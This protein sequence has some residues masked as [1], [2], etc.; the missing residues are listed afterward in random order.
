MSST[1]HPNQPGGTAPRDPAELSTAD[2]LRQLSDQVRTLVT[3]EVQLAKAEVTAKGKA[4]GIGAGLAGAGTML[5]LAGGLAF[6]AA[7]IA[8]LALVL[9]VWASALIVGAVLVAMGGLLALVAKKEISH[10]SP[11]VPEQAIDS[12]KADVET[13]RREVHR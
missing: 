9:P 3:D 7:A 10:A 1:L 5:A 13:I 2:L 6:V 11:P 8:A 12:T 4:V